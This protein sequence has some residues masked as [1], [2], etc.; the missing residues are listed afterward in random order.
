VSLFGRIAWTGAALLVLAAILALLWKPAAERAF[1]T[2]TEGLLRDAE[3]NTEA[4]ATSLV[5]RAIE[6]SALSALAAGEQRA[7]AIEDLPMDLYTDENGRLDADRLR[8]TLRTIVV[9]P[10]AAG[11][12]KHAAVRAEI[13][14]RTRRDVQA[15]LGELRRARS[16][17]ASR[18]AETVTWRTLAA[19][20]GI[21]LVLLAAWAFLLDRVVVRPM[22]EATAA[23]ARFGA[24]ERGLRLA[25]HGAAELAALANAFNETAKRVEEAERENA[26]LRAR[27]EEKVKE[28]TQAL[29]RAAR[30]STA[31]TMAGGIAHEFNNLLG[32]ILGCADA[33]LSEEP[34]PDVKESLE[35]IRKT[36]GRGVGITSALLRATRAEPD[37][38]PCDARSLVEEALELARPPAEVE[39]VR[40]LLPVPLVA[41][42]TMLRQVL[43]NLIRNAIEA[44]GGRG[45]LRL[46]TKGEGGEATI[47]VEDSGPGIAEAV[48]EVL[49]E[50]FVTTRRG[51]R[52]GAGLGLFLADR[53]VAAHGGRI[54]VASEPGNG[55]RFVVRLPLRR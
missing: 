45:R 10:G 28:R 20:G 33:A 5:N 18:H 47:V 44:M 51:G 13:L 4:M 26:E 23:V 14:E 6:F 17:E 16:V 30:S 25:P 11:G 53:L 3:R 27:L 9:D 55:A 21:L 32:G 19:W 49:F 50:P 48:K 34:P 1:V 8:E 24:G 54:E 40:D 46:A 31:G 52:E 2:R 36:A 15:R 39:V 7:L 41:D 43:G 29:V 42:V 22:R 38:T 12:E 37:T 35:M